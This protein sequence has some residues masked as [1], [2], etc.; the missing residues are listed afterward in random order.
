MLIRL[1]IFAHLSLW[2]HV[3]TGQ[4]FLTDKST[5]V[6]LEIPKHAVGV[7]ACDN[8]KGTGFVVGSANRVVTCAHVVLGAK[9]ILM[10]FSDDSVYK[11]LVVKIDTASDLALLSCDHPICLDPLRSGDISE[12][13]TGSR[14]I[15]IGLMPEKDL[16]HDYLDFDATNILEK[17]KMAL[18]SGAVVNFIMFLGYAVHGSSGGPIINEKTGKVIAIMDRGRALEKGSIDWAIDFSTIL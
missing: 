17:G 8:S 3:S 2:L 15:C 4:T 18:P 11:L 10:Q 1:I 12:T 13:D 16:S 5:G 7:I 14:I 6:Q 9:T